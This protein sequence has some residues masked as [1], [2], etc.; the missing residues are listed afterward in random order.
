MG[1][2]PY[3]S[4]CNLNLPAINNVL[5]I[6]SLS[7]LLIAIFYSSIVCAIYNHTDIVDVN[8]NIVAMTKEESQIYNC[9]MF[10]LLSSSSVLSIYWFSKVSKNP[11]KY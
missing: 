2:S 9:S 4:M 7:I 10:I 1:T 3:L 11:N 5:K 6:I 8:G